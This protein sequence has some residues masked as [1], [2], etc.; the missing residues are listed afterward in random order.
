MEQAGKFQNIIYNKIYRDDRIL[1]FQGYHSLANIE[2]W[3]EDF[4][5]SINYLL[6]SEKL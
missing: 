3:L 1:I 4:Q 2:A 6:N 5:K